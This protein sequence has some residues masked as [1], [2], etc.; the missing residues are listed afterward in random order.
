[1]LPVPLEKLHCLRT[2]SETG[3]FLGTDFGSRAPFSLRKLRRSEF[4]RKQDSFSEPNTEILQVFQPV[5]ET[6]FSAPGVLFK[7]PL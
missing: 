5:L 3:Y 7:F 4:V 2:K 1:M 6:S